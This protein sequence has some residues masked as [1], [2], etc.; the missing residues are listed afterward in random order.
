MI[1]NNTGRREFLGSRKNHFMFREDGLEVLRHK[2]CLSGLDGME[3][4][5][6]ARMTFLSICSMRWELMISGEPKVMPW[7]LY[8]FPS[9]SNCMVNSLK[10]MRMRPK[11]LSHSAPNTISQPPMLIANI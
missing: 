7:N 10:S 3:L 2:G 4:G 1:M 9:W 6:N 11:V 5:N 8:C